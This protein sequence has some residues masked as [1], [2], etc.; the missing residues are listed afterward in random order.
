MFHE[1]KNDGHDFAGGESARHNHFFFFSV[2]LFSHRILVVMPS[3]SFSRWTEKKKK[4]KKPKDWDMEWT[5][6]NGLLDIDVVRH[7]MATD[8]V[9]N[10]R[11]VWLTVW[12][13]YYLSLLTHL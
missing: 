8:C 5:E 10:P 11:D 1:T 12:V 4:N 9:N 6:R 3:F 7:T 2:I 13:C